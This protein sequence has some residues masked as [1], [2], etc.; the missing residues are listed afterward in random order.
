VWRRYGDVAFATV[1]AVAVSLEAIPLGILTWT[2]AARLFGQHGPARIGSVLLAAVGS[3]AAALLVLT[4]YV[5][6]YQHL[7]DRRS[8]LVAE[9]R[10]AWVSTWLRVLDGT[11]PDPEAELDDAGVEAL[12]ALRDTLRGERSARIAELL[13]RHGAV[14]RL[15]RAA[16]K[17]RAPARLDA[18]A[19]LSSARIAS[20]LPTLIEAIRDPNPAV[21]V[22]A[23]RAAA[24]T[25]ARTDD[26]LDRDL[27]AVQL[28]SSIEAGRLPYGVVEEVVVLAEDSAP[29]VID[30][31][32][33]A[34]E[35]R[36]ASI[37]AALDGIGRLKLLVFAEEVVPF[38]LHP[39][40]EV[41][42]AALRAVSRLGFLP[43]PSHGIVVAALADEVDFIRIHAAAAA[44]L[45]PR[46]Q[47][48]SL[49]TDALGDRSWWVRRAAAD[50]LVAL[51]PGG[52]AQLGDAARAH[53][54]RF[55]RDMA[56]QAL[57]DHVPSLVKAVVG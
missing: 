8:R 26:P 49:L 47:A 14:T 4:T 9:R 54:D 44:R 12:V 52:L 22:A 20:A 15:R 24:R 10:Q 31:L 13:E 17:G 7:S 39:D 43:E 18:I 45:L 34:S 42:A 46:P 57:R 27:G 48:F 36:A 51:G 50:A 32:L 6:S 5:L 3:A 23:A 16:A 37:R 28:V 11:E 25:L 56:A 53:P 35:R 2:L 21:S 29:S 41:R 33:L 1:F 38:L 40:D 19:A 55:A 30:A